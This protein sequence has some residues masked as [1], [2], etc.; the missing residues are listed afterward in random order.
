MPRSRGFDHEKMAH[1][2]IQLR[3]QTLAAPVD[4]RRICCRRGVDKKSYSGLTGQLS[5][6]AHSTPAP[7]VQP[8]GVS[9]AAK[10]D[11]DTCLRAPPRIAREAATASRPTGVTLLR[12]LQKLSKR[13]R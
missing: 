3:L 5:Q 11:D 6:N 1:R 4:V 2:L 7:T 10:R 13:D 9:E 12:H 8:T